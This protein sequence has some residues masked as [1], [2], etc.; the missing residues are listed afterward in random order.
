MVQ[1]S[2][3]DFPPN[4]WEIIDAGEQNEQRMQ[5][6]LHQLSKNELA[7]FGNYFHYNVDDL[8]GQIQSKGN[9]QESEDIIEVIAGWVLSQGKDY[10]ATVFD[11]PTK[12]PELSES[13]SDLDNMYYHNNYYGMAQT[14]Y[15]DKY[16][17][18]FPEFSQ[19]ML[20]QAND[21]DETESNEE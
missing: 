14:L 6:T 15:E 10:F 18:P 8:V 16:H 21:G 4:F 3:L 17:E 13:D 2:D 19:S 1:F 20:E 9:S 7:V 5:H 12:F 11:N